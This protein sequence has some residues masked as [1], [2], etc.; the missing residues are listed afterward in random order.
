MG[1]SNSNLAKA[2]RMDRLVSCPVFSYHDGNQDT[3]IVLLSGLSGY[4]CINH[5]MIDGLVEHTLYS[6]MQMQVTVV[7]D[8]TVFT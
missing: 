1:V 8:L 3:Y 4:T 5:C 2:A 7:V 6:S